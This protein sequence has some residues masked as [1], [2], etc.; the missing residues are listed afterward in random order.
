MWN[1]YATLMYSPRH[2]D[3][4]CA[5]CAMRLLLPPLHA[6]TRTA[7]SPRHLSS[8]ALAEAEGLDLLLAVEIERRKP[9]PNDWDCTDARWVPLA[10]L[11]S[12]FA[13]APGGVVHA[14]VEILA[15]LGD[16]LT[17]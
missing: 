14:S 5:C 4:G 9:K 15:A 12:F 7:S 6:R 1:Q 16:S 10:E 2:P 3:L 11:D 13:T 17:S 8:E